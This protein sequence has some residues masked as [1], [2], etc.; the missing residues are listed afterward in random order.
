MEKK[1]SVEKKGIASS[2]NC[3]R[4]KTFPCEQ[5][6]LSLGL[7]VL[8]VC[9]TLDLNINFRKASAYRNVLFL[10]MFSCLQA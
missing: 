8:F 7:F 3:V 1:V 5:N 4:G 2:Q 10:G 6:W 9:S